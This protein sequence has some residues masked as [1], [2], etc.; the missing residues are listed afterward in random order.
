M[1]APT[2]H[3]ERLALRMPKHSDFKHWAAFFAS[4]RSVHEH[5]SLTP[6]DGM[7][8]WAADASIRHET[9]ALA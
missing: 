2:L 6:F 7:K 9:G 5:G 4:E 3:T 1:T 8:V